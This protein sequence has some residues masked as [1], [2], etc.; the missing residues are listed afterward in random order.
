MR[1][2]VHWRDLKPSR[3]SQNPTQNIIRKSAHYAH[4]QNVEDRVIDVRGLTVEE[5]ISQIELQLDTASLAGED[6]VKLIHGH[7]T[8]VLKRKIRSYLSRSVYVKKWSAG[9]AESGGDG[10]TWV[11]L[12][13]T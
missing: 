5:A 12:K 6:R 2:M 8:E 1:L 3:T 7:G 9:T 11:E 13:E 10:L 4:G